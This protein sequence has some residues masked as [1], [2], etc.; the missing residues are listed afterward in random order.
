MSHRLSATFVMA[1]IGS[2]SLLLLSLPVSGQAQT[3]RGAGDLPDASVVKAFIASQAEKSADLWTTPWGDPAIGGVYT[4]KDEANTPL[5]R[6]DEWAGRRIDTI[7]PEELAA[8]IARRQQI[9]LERA[10]FAG[11]SEQLIEEGVAIAV[12]IHWFD[13]LAAQNSRPW[14]VIDPPEGKIPPL[15]SGAEAHESHMPGF[16]SPERDSYADRSLTD[17][18]IGGTVWRTPS[19][20]GNSHE[21]FQTPD[22][23]VFRYESMRT[24]RIVRLNQRH[25]SPKIRPLYGDSI[26]WWDGDSLVIETTNFPEVVSYGGYSARSLRVIERLTRTGPGT[27]EWTMTLDNP[28]VWTQPWTY[29]YPMTQDET[30]PIYEYACHEGN[31]GLANIL[32]A[33]RA[34]DDAK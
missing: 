7:T 23:I 16:L 22:T 4:T 2:A 15:V 32:S 9:A 24:S 10:P 33:G 14:F 34:I 28:E 3:S 21:I 19:L 29:S 20:Y 17:R 12:P 31:F 6:P 30:Q 18:C 26:G 27:V 5:E 8:D 13:N 1:V 11:G 25:L